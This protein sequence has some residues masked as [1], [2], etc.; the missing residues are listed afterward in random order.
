MKYKGHRYAH[1]GTK[2]AIQPFSKN[3]YT[4]KD[5]RLYR[6]LGKPGEFKQFTAHVFA[7]SGFSQAVQKMLKRQKGLA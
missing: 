6:R 7:K 1:T 2:T 5:F 3:T 4:H